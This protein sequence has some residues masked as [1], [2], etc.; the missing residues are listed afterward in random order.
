VYVSVSS[1][2]LDVTKQKDLGG[3][4][5]HLFQQRFGEEKPKQQLQEPKEQDEP[6]EQVSTIAKEPAGQKP[7]DFKVLDDYSY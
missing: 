1:A 3:I 7:A 6:S 4:Q 2:M 5:R